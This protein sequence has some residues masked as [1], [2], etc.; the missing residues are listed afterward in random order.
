MCCDLQ[1]LS[2]TAP[3]AW[4]HTWLLAWAGTNSGQRSRPPN[5]QARPSPA[6]AHC[7]FHIHPS[8]YSPECAPVS[9]VEVLGVG[10]WG[11]ATGTPK[12]VF[13]ICEQ[14]I[15]TLTI[16]KNMDNVAFYLRPFGDNSMLLKM[17]NI[18]KGADV[19]IVAECWCFGCHGWSPR[20]A[21]GALL[22]SFCCATWASAWRG[23]KSAEQVPTGFGS[24]SRCLPFLSL[25]WI[26]RVW[27]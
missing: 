17:T 27:L 13:S 15:L 19:D 18:R 22:F 9:L 26:I 24:F 8:C 6:P 11:G 10:E 14:S 3:S 7:L 12:E 25:V 1:V 5:F 4:L 16:W 23:P 20:A 2:H 21:A